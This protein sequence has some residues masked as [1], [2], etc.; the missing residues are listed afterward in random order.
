MSK[1]SCSVI[2]M[3]C[4][5]LMY[6]RDDVKVGHCFLVMDDRKYQMNELQSGPLM[7]K[8]LMRICFVNSKWLSG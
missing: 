7:L 4:H 5:G 8:S 2:V 1:M 6:R 3:Y